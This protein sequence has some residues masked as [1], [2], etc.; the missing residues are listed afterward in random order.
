MPYFIGSSG[1]AQLTV[2]APQPGPPSW[3]PLAVLAV[4]AAAGIAFIL[5]E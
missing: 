3:L 2:V 1:T 4:L 5:R